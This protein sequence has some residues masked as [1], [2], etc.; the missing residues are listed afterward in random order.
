[1]S[2]MRGLA[3]PVFLLVFGVA[4][5]T[6]RTDD[7]RPPVFECPRSNPDC[8]PS[9]PPPVLGGGSGDGEGGSAGEPSEEG[10]EIRG[11]VEEFSDTAFSTTRPFRERAVVEASGVETTTVS[12]IFNGSNPFQ[13]SD[14]RLTTPIWV[15][16]RA[17]SGVS[18]LLRTLH[19][20]SAAA[21]DVALG[22]VPRATLSLI[23]SL[24]TLPVELDRNAGHAVL[25]LLGSTGSGAAG[26]HVTV[27]EAE[28]VAYASGGTFTDEDRGTGPTGLV[29]LGNVRTRAYPGSEVRV[30]FSEGATGHADI[31]VAADSV[32][33]VEIVLR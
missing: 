3:R 9:S 15:S 20:V 17:E 18:R 5:C 31:R 1:M 14:V 10:V 8:R 30:A 25:F 29:V 23:Y 2:A 4:G 24:L 33:L 6:V 7:E 21:E 22:M 27:P 32:S 28:V 16:V 13:L 11:I 12:A 19:P 26:V